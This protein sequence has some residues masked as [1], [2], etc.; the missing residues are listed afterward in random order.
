M[1]EVHNW[2]EL[3][4]LLIEL[5][6]A[7][8]AGKGYAPKNLIFASDG[9]KPDLVLIDSL[10]NE[11][12]IVND[13]GS[14][15]IYTRKISPGRGLSFREL[16]DWWKA[17][18]TPEALTADRAARSLYNR[19]ESGL[20]A[21]EREIMEAYRELLRTHG[22][23]LP[24]LIPQVYLHFDPKTIRQRLALDGKMLE[25]QRMDFLLLLPNNHRIVVELDGIEHYA[26]TSGKASPKRYAEMVREDRRLKLTGYDVYRVGGFEFKTLSEGRESVRSFFEELLDRYG[27]SL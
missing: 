14:C 10:D 5:E 26:N 27:V 13:D 6:M 16:V 23:D 21:P 8:F 25:R 11:T 2:A 7:V 22:F 1:A 15:L 18:H 24:A 17:E 9:P 20:N 19:L 4:E 12:Q 3:D